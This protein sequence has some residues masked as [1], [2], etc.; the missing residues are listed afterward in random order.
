MVWQFQATHPG[1]LSAYLPKEDGQLRLCT[2]YRRVNTVTVPDAYPI[3]RID[4]VKKKKA[5]CLH[6]KR[7]AYGRLKVSNGTK[8]KSQKENLEE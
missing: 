3:H 4:V 7:N 2:D 5:K 6:A 8:S 1:L